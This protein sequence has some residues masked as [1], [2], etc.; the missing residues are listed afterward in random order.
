MKEMFIYAKIDA[1]ECSL[2]V[3]RS[4]KRF[5]SQMVSEQVHMNSAHC[6]PSKRNKIPKPVC[7]A[8]IVEHSVRKKLEKSGH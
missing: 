1:P 2:C 8:T 4:E 5:Q 6:A 7:G 3:E